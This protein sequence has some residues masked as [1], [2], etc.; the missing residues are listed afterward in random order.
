MLG[1]ED[2][3]LNEIKNLEVCP[4]NCPEISELTYEDNVRTTNAVI[5]CVQQEV[6]FCWGN[7]YHLIKRLFVS[8]Q[9]L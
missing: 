5:F 2:I 9:H 6:I 8:N 1:A 7:I 3:Y 4:P